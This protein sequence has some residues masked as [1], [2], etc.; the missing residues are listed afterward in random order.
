LKVTSDRSLR[1]WAEASQDLI[2]IDASL[3]DQ[4]LRGVGDFLGGRAL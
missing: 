3:D 1:V 2:G 4:L